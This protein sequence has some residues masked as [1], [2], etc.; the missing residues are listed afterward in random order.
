MTCIACG[1][2]NLEGSDWC[3]RCLARFDDAVLTPE[4]PEAAVLDVADGDV[5]TPAGGFRRTASTTLRRLYAHGPLSY[6]EPGGDLQG[7]IAHQKVLA[8][9]GRREDRYSCVGT[10]DEVQFFVEPYRAV[11]RPAWTVFAVDGDPLAT[12][13]AAGG[14]AR[15][16][17][18][19]RDGTGAPVASLRR[20]GSRFDV[21]ETSGERV[22]QVW[23]DTTAFDTVVHDEWGLTVFSEPRLLGR[24]ALAA[25]PLVSWLVWG[26]STR[27][28]IEG[29]E[30]LGAAAFAARSARAVGGMAADVSFALGEFGL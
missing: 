20:A 27:P 1:A 2:R 22:A 6:I 11:D 30:S 29:P 24:E 14:V 19:V 21:Y 3:A 28:R 7:V 18:E 5:T 9:D 4:P 13:I 12:M 15:R 16:A 26:R 10:D 25:L 23:R 8:D 17:M